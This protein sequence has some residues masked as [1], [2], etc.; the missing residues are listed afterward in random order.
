MKMEDKTFVIV[1]L[2]LITFAAAMYVVVDMYLDNDNIADRELEDEMYANGFTITFTQSTGYSK[3]L[4]IEAGRDV[5]IDDGW[6][7]IYDATR[8]HNLMYAI[9]MD[10]ILQIEVK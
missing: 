7:L 3:Y 6:V 4:S 5:I 2:G 1:V 8:S 10:N 9:P